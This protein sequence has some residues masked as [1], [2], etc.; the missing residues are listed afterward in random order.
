LSNQQDYPFVFLDWSAQELAIQLTLIEM[1]L[2]R[3]I[4]PKECF[5]LS[6][7][8]QNKEE[9]APNIVAI[10][11]RFNKISV[12]ISSTILKEKD[13]KVRQVIISR[14]MEIAKHCY[15]LNNYTTLNQVNAA[16]NSSAVYRMKKSWEGIKEEDR[17]GFEGHCSLFDKPPYYDLKM[18]LLQSSGSASVPFVG[19]YLTELTFIEDGN[20]NT[21]VQG[22]KTYVNF[23]KRRLF[24]DTL[25]SIQLYQQQQYPYT[26]LPYLNWWLSI[27]YWKDG[28]MTPE[29]L[30]EESLVLEPRMK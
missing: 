23:S 15:D 12:W 28:L 5:G 24:F 6:W 14:W 29:Q 8:K 30:Y 27:G 3:R 22:E 9:L 13:P 25:K 16:L 26:I 18:R 17:K 21:V 1:D 4:E 7:S 10:S 20:P 2:F 19:V 11:D